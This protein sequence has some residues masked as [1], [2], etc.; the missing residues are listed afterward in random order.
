MTKRAILALAGSIATEDV[1]SEIKDSISVFYLMDRG[2]NP[3]KCNDKKHRIEV[4]FY[5]ESVMTLYTRE[6]IS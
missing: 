5:D 4:V 3:A 6:A 2:I 1:I